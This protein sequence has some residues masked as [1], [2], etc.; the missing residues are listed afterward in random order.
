MQIII[1][2]LFEQQCH[3][4]LID[5]WIQILCG[6]HLCHQY[7][8]LAL[9]RDN[10]SIKFVKWNHFW[11]WARRR[12][13]TWCMRWVVHCIRSEWLGIG[14]FME[15]GWLL[16]GWWPSND[17]DTISI[18]ICEIVKRGMIGERWRF[19][20]IRC[21]KSHAMMSCMNSWVMFLDFSTT[22][23]PTW[24]EMLLGVTWS[25]GQDAW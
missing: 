6:H 5:T 19:L 1:N 17:Q 8:L 7:R 24:H 23:L 16:I 10:T 3:R 12:L 13:I 4:S 11:V 18:A 2:L 14:M 9:G 25:A 20:I 22:S 15:C 21:W